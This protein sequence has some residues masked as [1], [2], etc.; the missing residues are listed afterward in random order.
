MKSR[1]P[2]SIDQ[3]F[4]FKWYNRTMSEAYVLDRVIFKKGQQSKYILACKNKLKLSY[5]SMSKL[6]GVSH[7]TIYLWAKEK[8][9]ISH[10]AL[11]ELSTRSGISVPKDIKVIK[12]IDHLSVAGKKGGTVRFKKYGGICNEEKRKDAWYKWW[13]EK[14]I[15]AINPI[16]DRKE[17]LIPVKSEKLAEFVGIIIGDGSISNYSVRITLDSVADKEYVT[18]VKKIIK[19]LFGIDSIVYKHKKF[20]AVDLVIHR[21]NLVDYCKSIGLKSGNKIKN[22]IDIP[23][24]IKKDSKLSIACVRGLVDTDG[25]VFKH[26]Y[27]VGKKV[28]V[29]NK[30]AFTSKSKLVLMSVADIL[31]KLGFCVRITK[32]G[33]DVRIEN[34]SDVSK[35]LKIIG[36]GN[37]KFLKKLI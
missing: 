2:A 19:D 31:I 27:R 13:N 28:Y 29:Y 6:F 25:C 18:Y 14:G 7:K 3:V 9:K 4:C 35:Y 11:L 37:N 8:R 16:Y 12:W 23:E 33:N 10:N 5:S 26:S 30:I 20:R 36:T 24:W 15:H 32:D 22:N 17:I 1:T 34:K 21:R